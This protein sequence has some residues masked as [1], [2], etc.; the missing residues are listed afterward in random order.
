MGDSMKYKISNP[1]ASV[2]DLIESKDNHYKTNLHTHSTYSDANNTMVEMIEEFY[3]QD[4]D[5]L[6]FAEHG[7]LGKEWDKEPSIIPL[8]LFQN[9]W[10]GKRKHINSAEFKAIQN[11]TYKT[12]KKRMALIR[13][14]LEFGMV[15]YAYMERTLRKLYRFYES[16]IGR[17]TAQGQ[18]AIGKYLPVFV[19]EF[20]T[21]PV[22]FAD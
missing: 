13:T 3:D 17:R 15:L 14:A 5:I 20:I 18:A 21:V 1:Y 22:P 4:F 8:F 2:A 16:A 10:H 6:A 19:I 9:L 7:I 11:G 12:F